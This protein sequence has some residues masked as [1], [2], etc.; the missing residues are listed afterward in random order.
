VAETA[1]KSS[2]QPGRTRS[3]SWGVMSSN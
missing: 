1:L 3:L 2:T